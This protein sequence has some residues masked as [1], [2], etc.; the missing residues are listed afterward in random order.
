MQRVRLRPVAL[1]IDAEQKKAVD[2]TFADCFFI[3]YL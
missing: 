3:V 1:A 2:E